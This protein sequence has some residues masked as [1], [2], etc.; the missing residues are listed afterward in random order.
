MTLKVKSSQ[1]SKLKNI[2]INF[3]ITLKYKLLASQK[4]LIIM[5]FYYYHYIVLVIQLDF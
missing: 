4:F 5:N 1:I 3:K 2:F